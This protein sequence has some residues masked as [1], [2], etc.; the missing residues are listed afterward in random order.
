MLGLVLLQALYLL[1]V[2]AVAY[3]TW[4]LTMV[5]L[6][7]GLSLNALTIVLYA[8]PPVAGLI[9]IFFLLKPLMIRPPRA[10]EPLKLKREEEALLFEYIDRV[11]QCLGSPHPS[12]TFVDLRANASASVRGWRGFLLGQ[13]DLTIGLPLAVGLTLPEFTGVLA[14]EFGHFAQ[15]TGMRSHFLIQTIQHWF[16]RVVNQ[17]DGMDEWLDRLHSHGDLRIKTVALVAALT[18]AGSRKYLAL[19]MKAGAWISAAFSRQM[20]FDADRHEVA[21]VGVEVFEQT[22]RRIPLLTM[23]V[24]IAW[25]DLVQ[26]WSVG[27]LPEDLP[28]L[29]SMRTEWLPNETV[30]RIL[31]DERSVKTGQWD[32]HP[33]MS[34]RILNARATSIMGGLNLEG[35]P[36]NLFSD[37]PALCREATI[38]HYK[39]VLKLAGE[40]LRLVPV[41]EAIVNAQA[42]RDY[43]VAVQKLFGSTPLFCSRWFRLPISEPHIDAHWQG[44][45]EQDAPSL[46]AAA[47]DSA[48]QTNLLHFAALIVAQAGVR[49]NPQSFRLPDAD[50]ETIRN[51]ESTTTDNLNLANEQKREATR[52][53]ASRIEST[54]AQLMSGEMGVAIPLNREAIIPDIRAAWQSYGVLS[55]LEDE[56]MEIRHYSF[57]LQIVRENAK[58]FPAAACAN[59]IEDLETRALSTI[60][61]V[62]AKCAV[63]PT[64][65]QFDPRLPATVRCQLE[66]ECESRS[67]RIQLFLARV[68]VIAARTLGQLAWLTVSATQ[69]RKSEPTESARQEPLSEPSRLVGRPAL[70]SPAAGPS[71]SNG[72]AFLRTRRYRHAHAFAGVGATGGR[73]QR[74]S[75]ALSRSPYSPWTT[76]SPEIS[77]QTLP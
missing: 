26:D 22:S 33:C 16:F 46:D 61:H 58:L 5:A 36:A 64:T 8:G 4:L 19:L 62:L 41:S 63:T 21:I 60:D 12:R 23:G 59:L 1:L 55:N 24:G 14:H 49:V 35:S 32:T 44:E 40:Q 67:E 10:P 66:S 68:E 28:Q 7:M 20:E 75:L 70:N 45:P 39:T 34:E 77:A 2:I 17:R 56:I 76:P 69:I 13:L 27:R 43:N 74:S 50:L 53:I 30:E 31:I 42:E 15:H 65:V 52:H 72:L 3:L 47:Y 6:G 38:H 37:L 25:S 71:G 51:Q 29:A 48:V 57:A 54:I 9:V 73:C 11:C 18:I